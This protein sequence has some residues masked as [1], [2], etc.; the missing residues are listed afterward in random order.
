MKTLFHEEAFLKNNGNTRL[1]RREV[2]QKV[3]EKTRPISTNPIKASIIQQY[4]KWTNSWYAFLKNRRISIQKEQ[5]YK[6]QQEH[7][8]KTYA[9]T[10]KKF[11]E[12]VKKVLASQETKQ[13]TYLLGT[14]S[15]VLE[16][17]SETEIKKLIAGENITIKNTD[18]PKDIFRNNFIKTIN[19]PTIEELKKPFSS[20]T[21]AKNQVLEYFKKLFIAENQSA[22]FSQTKI[23][24]KDLLTYQKTQKKLVQL[25]IERTASQKEIESLK[26]KL[27]YSNDIS[28]QEFV[29]R[30]PE[31]KKL[32]KEGKLCWMTKDGWIRDKRQNGRSSNLY[33]NRKLGKY[34]GSLA[35]SRSSWSPHLENVLTNLSKKAHKERL[36]SYRGWQNYYKEHPL[37]RE[38]KRAAWTTR[39]CQLETA[40]KNRQSFLT[41]QSKTLNEITNKTKTTLWSNYKWFG[42]TAE[43]RAFDPLTQ[44]IIK[45]EKK[46]PQQ[47]TAKEFLDGFNT[48]QAQFLDNQQSFLSAYTPAHISLSSISTYNKNREIGGMLRSLQFYATPRGENIRNSLYETSSDGRHPHGNSGRAAISIKNPIISKKPEEKKILTEKVKWTEVL[49]SITLGAQAK[50]EKLTLKEKILNLGILNFKPVPLK[51]NST[52]TAIRYKAFLEASK[53]MNYEEKEARYKTFWKI[54]KDD[55]TNLVINIAGLFNYKDKSGFSIDAITQTLRNDTNIQN[56]KVITLSHD[57]AGSGWIEGFFRGGTALEE[58][59]QTLG[60]KGKLVLTGHSL[61]GDSALELAKRLEKENIDVDLMVTIDSVGAA[62]GR[63]PILTSLAEA[64]GSNKFSSPIKIPDNIKNH[65]NFW[66]GKDAFGEGNYYNTKGNKDFYNDTDIPFENIEQGKNHNEMMKDEKLKQ[67][68]QDSIT[69]LFQ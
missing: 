50:I 52:Q 29:D 47:T 28:W 40:E 59:K 35:R 32:Q 48:K 36:N 60:K 8:I 6:T 20:S 56:T 7:E 51:D 33:W 15:Q 34:Y 42:K 17:F 25:Q 18:S 13:K 54:Q 58:I 45:A 53:K 68:I 10:I 11:G 37:V 65:I 23:N 26:L 44:S 16:N 4:N 1:F 5:N 57:E 41:D 14:Y 64:F 69:T 24:S 61:G 38:K 55:S 43:E 3:L 30:T 27:S 21:I 66:E 12:T 31:L 19:T 46:L 62:E 22:Y 2:Y 63:K 49:K 39:L 67:K 9:E